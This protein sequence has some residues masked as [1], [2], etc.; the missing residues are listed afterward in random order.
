M[1]KNEHSF[2]ISASADMQEVKNAVNQA[3]KEVENRYDF[4]GLDKEIDLNEKD[5]FITLLTTSDQKVDAMLDI[6]ISKASKRGI[7]PYALKLEKTE[8]ASGNKRKAYVKIVDTI[9]QDDAKKIVK[10]IKNTKLKV[11][12]QIQGE[13]I[14]VTAKSIDDLQAVIAHLKGLELD[15]PLS[16]GNFK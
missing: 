13:E 1:A 9:N 16:F 3:V 2:D 12:S 10:E 6:L 11:N 15:L 4:K 8:N 7:S 5:K 14:R